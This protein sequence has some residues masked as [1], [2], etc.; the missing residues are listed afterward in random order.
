[1]KHFYKKAV[2][3][4][5]YMN[6][7]GK[8]YFFIKF[9]RRTT[10]L[11]PSL[12]CWKWR[13]LYVNRRHYKNKALIKK[14]LMLHLFWILDIW[15]LQHPLQII[16]NSKNF[17]VTF[18]YQTTDSLQVN[19][20]I[21][22]W[23]YKYG[24]NKDRMFSYIITKAWSNYLPKQWV[25]R[26]YTYFVYWRHKNKKDLLM[27][28]P[29]LTYLNRWF[30]DNRYYHRIQANFVCQVP[31]NFPV[32][33]T[34]TLWLRLFQYPSIYNNNWFKALQELS[35]H[36]LKNPLPWNILYQSKVIWTFDKHAVALENILIL[37]IVRRVYITD[38]IIFK[39]WRNLLTQ[40]DPLSKLVQI[41]VRSSNIF[42][43]YKKRRVKTKKNI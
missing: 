23:Q 18:N 15:K 33:Y 27:Q 16:G 41:Y 36:G 35:Y 29:V 2:R 39:H 25:S 4:Q 40:K 32:K 1:M 6:M 14:T 31:L 22:Q 24:L 3:S 26:S 38:Y 12:T 13:S 19:R 34:K 8:W 5:N 30:I 10:F 28:Y 43:S 7:G 11:Y 20:L 9:F 37:M 21:H 42:N 17:P